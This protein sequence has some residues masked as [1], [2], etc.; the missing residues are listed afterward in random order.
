MDAAR[1]ALRDEE[2]MLQRMRGKL[3]R[4]ARQLPFAEDLLAAYFCVR[5]PA[6]PPR[7]R[8]ILLLALAYFVLPV[9]TV[10][11][12]LPVLGFTDDA[13]VLATALASV[14]G[15]LQPE[16]RERARETLDREQV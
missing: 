1:S 5:D 14:R 13:A 6:T 15:A 3:R 9:D 16:H 10:P 7:I 8:W 12:V 4:L 2:D 11:D